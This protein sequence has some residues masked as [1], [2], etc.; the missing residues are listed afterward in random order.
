MLKK[1]RD[2]GADKNEKS[3]NETLLKE[4]KKNLL[5]F[6]E[7]KNSDQE[8]A[9]DHLAESY[10]V[11][12]I[13]E[14]L[15]KNNIQDFKVEITTAYQDFISEKADFI[16]E[17]NPAGM[18]NQGNVKPFTI[19][20][21]LGLI[22]AQKSLQAKNE[23]MRAIA[24]RKI[25]ENQDKNVINVPFAPVALATSEGDKKRAQNEIEEY[26]ND[27]RLA[28]SQVE[29]DGQLNFQGVKHPP[30]EIT[31]KLLSSILK[32]LKDENNRALDHLS[33]ATRDAYVYKIEELAAKLDRY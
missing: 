15:K 2:L 31:Y 33:P 30:L 19:Y 29:T 21:D 1:R 23:K 32:S 3:W 20:V 7:T 13:A 24:S 4:I 17:Y 14:V 5:L 18:A 22:I 25:I 9:L 27:L 28:L 16:F 12:A 26:K 10:F 8:Q 6:S 11:D